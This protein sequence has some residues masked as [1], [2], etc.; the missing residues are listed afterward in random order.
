MFLYAGTTGAL[1]RMNVSDE[2]LAMFGIPDGCT[3]TLEFDPETNPQIVAALTGQVHGVLW[4]DIRL[5]GGVLSHKGTPV[6]VNPPGPAWL[7]RVDAEDAKARILA[8]IDAALA[9]YAA[10]L[11]RWDVLTTVQQKA[12]LRRLVEVQAQLLRYHRRE[13]L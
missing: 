7:A 5:S 13:W 9:D 3:E 1:L 6:T 4:Q 2:D 10:A 12:V 8:A 11:D